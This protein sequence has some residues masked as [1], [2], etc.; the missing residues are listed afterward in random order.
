MLNPNGWRNF[1]H[2]G[3]DPYLY[4][5]RANS[6]AYQGGANPCGYGGSDRDLIRLQITFNGAYDLSL[7]KS[8]SP[9]PVLV[10]QPLTYTLSV[11][12]NGPANASGVT[13]TDVLPA[14]MSFDSAT[15]SQGNCTEN[16]GTVACELGAV[17]TGGSATVQIAVTPQST[18]TMTNTASV[19]GPRTSTA[20]TTSRPSRRQSPARTPTLRSRRRTS[21]TRWSRAVS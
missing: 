7:S 13:L 21:P 9:D 19:Q 10:G 6:H 11:Q 20:P 5:R 4:L 14:G 15:P 1:D 2:P 16:S 12:N 17:T 8:S 3:R 18:G